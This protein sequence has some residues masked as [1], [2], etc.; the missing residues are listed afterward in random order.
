MARIEKNASV[1]KQIQEVK[2]DV[3]KEVKQRNRQR[4]PWITCSLIALFLIASF[5]IWIGWLIAATGLVDVPVFTRFAYQQ[6]IPIHEVEAG[7][8]VEAMVQERFATILTD[9]LYE[10]GGTIDDRTI[11]L[12]IPDGSLTTS[13]RNLLE[14]TNVPMIDAAS[15]QVAV[16]SEVGIEIFAPLADSSLGTA[17]VIRFDIQAI[18]GNIVVAPTSV[19]LGSLSIPAFVLVNIFEP[20]IAEQLGGIN[21]ELSGYASVGSISMEQGALRVNGEIAVEIQEAQ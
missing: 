4:R 7:T 5:F 16:D 14:E 21:N 10:G 15:L 6:P 3:I 9:R 11:E 18:D 20:L 8:T 2:G 1:E 19:E 17:V 13:T 12:L